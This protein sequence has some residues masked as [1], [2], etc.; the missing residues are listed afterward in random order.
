MENVI[1]PS[2]PPQT[3]FKATL[4]KHF[5]TFQHIIMPRVRNHVFNMLIKSLSKGAKMAIV[6]SMCFKCELACHF[7]YFD[8]A[9]RSKLRKQ[10]DDVLHHYNTER[11]L[12]RNDCTITGLLSRPLFTGPGI[13]LSDHQLPVKW[14]LTHWGR[15]KMADFSRR[16]F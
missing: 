1:T 14:A 16:H 6:Q 15:D 9:V 8:V 2:H 10:Y 7:C 12:T 13:Q 11:W 3:H 5:K 4:F